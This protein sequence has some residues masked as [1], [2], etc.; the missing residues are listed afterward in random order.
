[1]HVPWYRLRVHNRCVSLSLF[2]LPPYPP[3]EAYYNIFRSKL[4]FAVILGVELRWLDDGCELAAI[5]GIA[6]LTPQVASQSQ[7]GLLREFV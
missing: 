3:Y 1:M 6:K 4:R 5:I 2:V 7:M